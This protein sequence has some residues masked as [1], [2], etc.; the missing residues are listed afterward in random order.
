MTIIRQKHD[1]IVIDRGVSDV[2]RF[3]CC[4]LVALSH[5]SQH[6]IANGLNFNVII[7]LLSSQGG[8]LGVSVFF[9]LSGF[10]LTESMRNNPINFK[11]FAKNRI[12]K[13]YVPAVVV[14]IIWV[15]ILWLK[16]KLHANTDMCMS[17]INVFEDILLVFFMSF[18][19]SVLWFVKVIMILYVVFFV[20]HII[21]KKNNNIGLCVLIIQSV[22]VTIATYY[23]IAPFACVSIFAFALG[24]IVS[25]YN[26]FISRNK[27][28]FLIIGIMTI[29]FI[30]CIIRHNSFFLHGCI[31]Y[32]LLIVI[33]LVFCL[34]EIRLKSQKYLSNLSY[35]LYL[36]HNKFKIWM[37]TY[38]PSMNVF[39]FVISIMVIAVCY[40]LIYSLAYNALNNVSNKFSSY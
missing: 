7:N 22:F 13:V 25:D 39:L 28:S 17:N 6:A 1:V 10:G 37:V 30:A 20:Y 5:Y 27:W 9:L 23:L 26:Q 2:L 12:S 35:D 3:L 16:L 8:Y 15:I 4:L 11:I 18:Q 21:K 36:T 34:F 38:Y 31:N 14:S 19:D 40:N 29:S 32:V 33:I 24:I